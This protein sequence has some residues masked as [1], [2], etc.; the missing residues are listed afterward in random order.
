M[1]NKILSKDLKMWYFILLKV[2]RNKILSDKF[3]VESNFVELYILDIV[4]F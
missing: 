4:E 2:Y 1:L 3:F